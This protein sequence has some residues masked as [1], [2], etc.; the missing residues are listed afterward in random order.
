MVK[1]LVGHKGSGKTKQMI[2]LAN[3]QIETSK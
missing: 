3:D 1:L 2:D